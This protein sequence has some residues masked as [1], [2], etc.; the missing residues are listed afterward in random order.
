[1][2]VYVIQIPLQMTIMAASEE[3]AKQAAFSALCAMDRELSTEGIEVD[4]QEVDV[5]EVER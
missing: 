4:W 5:A 1:M 3:V 2:K